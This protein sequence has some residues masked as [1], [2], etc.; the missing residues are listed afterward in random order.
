MH[1]YKSPPNRPD[2]RGT[3]EA[4]TTEYESLGGDD[5]E[6]RGRWIHATWAGSNID[7]RFIAQAGQPA[8]NAPSHYHGSGRNY[9][10]FWIW[11]D[12]DAEL[13][14]RR[15]SGNGAVDVAFAVYTNLSDFGPEAFF[16]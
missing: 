2:S 1:K 10:S 14:V 13:W 6:G 16:A 7:L 9:G 12:G 3:V 8:L 15:S 5:V 11:V 4:N